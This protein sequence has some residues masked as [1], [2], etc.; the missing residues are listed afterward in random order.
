MAPAQ[1]WEPRVVTIRSDPSAPDS[2][3]APQNRIRLSNSFGSHAL[4]QSVK[5]SQR[6]SPGEHQTHPG[7]VQGIHILQSLVEPSPGFAKDIEDE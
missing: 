5:I 3:A 6:R 2:I 7:V 4:A 1:T